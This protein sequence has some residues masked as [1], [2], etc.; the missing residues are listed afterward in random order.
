[1]TEEQRR[2]LFE[3]YSLC[4]FGRTVAL[5]LCERAARINRIAALLTLACVAG[6]LLA[7]GIAFLAQDAFKPYWA[8]LN[9]AAVMPPGSTRI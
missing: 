8:V 3:V 7:G 5:D 1:M 6:S 9:I 4:Q 2:R